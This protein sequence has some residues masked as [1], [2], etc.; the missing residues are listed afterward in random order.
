MTR[1][2]KTL[3]QTALAFLVTAAVSALLVCG[4]LPGPA[5]PI[6]PLVYFA[7]VVVLVLLGPILFLWA[8]GP[9][10]PS[11]MAI[12]ALLL[13]WLVSGGLYYTWLTHRRSFARVVASA[14]VWSAFGG[15]SAY[16]AISG[17]I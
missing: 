4:Q 15:F 17:S 8:W 11:A 12:I 16:L 1:L 9:Q 5:T 7:Y 10:P 14:M 6:S 2:S 3:L 13:T